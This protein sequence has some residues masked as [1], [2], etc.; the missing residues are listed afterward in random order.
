MKVASRPAISI[1]SVAVWTIF[2]VAC[3]AMDSMHESPDFYR[4][5]MSQLS[6]PPDGTSADFF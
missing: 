4:H 6:Q 3:S 1:V 2:L 5:S